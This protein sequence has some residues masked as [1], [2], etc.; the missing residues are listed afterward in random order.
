MQPEISIVVPIYKVEKYLD[1]CVQSIINQSYGNIEII[2]VDDGS[3]DN[4]PL[5]CDSYAKQDTRIRVVHKSNGGLSDARNVGT[6]EAMGKYILFVDSDDF[7]DIDTCQ[8]FVDAINN[9]TPEIVVGN[10]RIIQGNQTSIMQH[11]SMTL[12]RIVTGEQYL[13]AELMTETMYMAAWLNLYRKDFLLNNG[14]E[15]KVGLL[16]EDEQFTPR[17]FLEA[18]EVI[19][20]DIIFY[21]YIIR[22]G[23]ITKNRD[24]TKNG[25]HIVQTCYELVDIYEDLED[26]ELRGMLKNNLVT[27]Y[28]IGFQIG[29]L[30]RKE[31]KGL[32]NRNFLRRNASTRKNKCKVLIFLIS[33]NLYYRLNHLT[34]LGK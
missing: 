18:K 23:S 22:E 8:R 16:H 3:P 32:I 26:E 2:L 34:K 1:K 10:A 13:K 11:Q 9:R 30:F 19:G 20:T 25:I 31:Y 28:L 21:N 15:F 27:K 5:K 33:M 24:R 4:C 14:L 29:K 12:S 7:I 6:R 17:A